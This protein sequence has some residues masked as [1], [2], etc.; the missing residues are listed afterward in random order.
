MD[1]YLDKLSLLGIFT[2]FLSPVL[3]A[4]I[5]GL[6]LIVLWVICGWTFCTLSLRFINV[7]FFLHAL[8]IIFDRKT[9]DSV[10]N[11]YINHFQA[12]ST[13]VAGTVGL[14]TISGVA[15]ALSI[16]GPGAMGWMFLCG[17]LGM[18]CKFVEVVLSFKYRNVSN[19]FVFSGPF[20]YIPKAFKSK[21]VGKVVAVVYAILILLALISGISFQANQSV[22]LV[23]GYSYFLDENIWCAG[24]LFTFCIGFVTIGGIGRIANLVS[25]IVPFMVV[26]H[27][28]VCSIIIIV[29]IDRFADTAIQIL[30]CMFTERAF[31]GGFF[32]AL[33]VGVRRSLFASEAGIGTASIAHA[34]T[35]ETEPV[36][37][38]LVAMLTP[39]VDTMLVC[40]F[41]GFALL[42]INGDQ[43][44]SYDGIIAVRE[45]F[46]SVSP[47]FNLS[48]S[49]VTPLFG[50]S[51]I[52]AYAYYCEVSW[53]Y[54]YKK[55]VILI[56]FIILMVVFV[57]SMS[58][59]VIDI[60]TMSDAMFMLLTIPNMIA[61]Y[62]LCGAVRHEA[63]LYRKK[64]LV[65]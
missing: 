64:R 13:A 47:L 31:G 3:F 23:R 50:F 59:N 24:L 26:L 43:I 6:P 21:I 41:T 40:F 53:F 10:G 52:I 15:I 30:D 36:R 5:F 42:S 61:I 65:A 55:R 16:G 34:P 58:T 18:S 8:S 25:K 60:A 22:V 62:F 2:E 7:R 12:F 17:F 38:G 28:L 57:S 39:C 33:I 54:L 48:V 56:R 29:N 51:T 1:L 37:A 63:E 27:V 44:S 49:I 20:E 32:G 4:D 9:G 45:A 11:V 14:G 35:K 19:D 46:G